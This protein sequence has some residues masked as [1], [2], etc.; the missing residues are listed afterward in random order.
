MAAR[1]LRHVADGERRLLMGDRVEA[2]PGARDLDIVGG[3]SGLAPLQPARTG[4]E[5]LVLRFE[6]DPWPSKLR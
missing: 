1:H 3:A 6:V 5:D 2:D 4:S